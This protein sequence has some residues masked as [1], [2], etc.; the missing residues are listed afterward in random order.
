[1]SELAAY[2]TLGF[3]HITDLEAMDHI[4][5]LFALA[6]I[7]RLRDW[8]DS[9]WV[10]TAFTVGHS[11]TLA[12]AVTGTLVLPTR[13]IE[14]LI[15][16]TIVA[17]CLDNLIPSLR[18]VRTVGRYRPVFAGVFGLVHGAGFA[19]YLRSMFVDQI[20]LPLFGFNVGIELGQLVVLAIAAA[21]LVALDRAFALVVPRPGQGVL[22]LRVVA[23][24]AVVA[25]IA[26]RWAVERS[27]F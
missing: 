25:L 6:A 22:R 9:L 14:F 27:P 26:A 12:L 18:G 24:S 15:P 2:I 5:F 8:R 7:Y 19:N 23:V 16:V 20:A 17:T 3:R 21:A 10:V 11:V 4:L 1:M 13:L